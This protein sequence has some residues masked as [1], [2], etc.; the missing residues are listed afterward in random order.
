MSVSGVT[1]ACHSYHD[2]HDVTIHGT[3]LKGVHS[4]LSKKWNLLHPTDSHFTQYF[5]IAWSA[6]YP[7]LCGCAVTVDFNTIC[8]Y[9]TETF[10][11][12]G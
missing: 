8:L 9:G 10:K 2:E 6:D 7:D 5:R 3:R 4:I 12:G 1:T 11:R